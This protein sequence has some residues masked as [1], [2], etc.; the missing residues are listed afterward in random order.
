VTLVVGIFFVILTVQKSAAL[1]LLRA[2]GA[3]SG[4]LVRALLVQVVLVML[5]AIAVGAVLMGLSSLASS[6]DFPISLDPSIVLSRGV[7]LL[8]LALV[9]SLAAVRRVLRID[10][11]AATVPAGV[12]R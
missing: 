2:I 1:T 11:I 8:V 4:E 5:A 6:P 10:P 12:D 3:T 9:A 7:A